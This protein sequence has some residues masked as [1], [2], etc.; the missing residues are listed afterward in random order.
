M[1]Q[2]NLIG[3]VARRVVSSAETVQTATTFLSLR[4]DIK[5]TSLE[6]NMVLLLTPTRLSSPLDSSKLE[7]L[8]RRF[9]FT[10][11]QLYTLGILTPFSKALR[12]IQCVCDNLNKQRS[13]HSAVY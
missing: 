12:W 5:A 4:K 8:S 2:S 10:L 1:F 7:G 9:L 6:L 13:L 3:Y 11:N